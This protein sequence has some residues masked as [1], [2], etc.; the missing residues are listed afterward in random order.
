MTNL[1]KYFNF[2]CDKLLQLISKRQKP[3]NE[4]KVY[5]LK[6]DVSTLSEVSKCRG[7]KFEL[8]IKNG[9]NNL[10]DCENKSSDY[11]KDLL[12]NSQIGQ[13]FYQMKFDVPE[14]FYDDTG[15]K[16]IKFERFI[17]DI[18][19]VKE[20]DCKKKLMIYDAKSSKST[21]VSHQIFLNFLFHVWNLLTRLPLQ[22]FNI[23]FLL[24]KINKFFCEELPRIITTERPW[25][26]NSRCRTCD[27]VDK[28]KE[29]AE[30]DEI[31]IEDLTN[32]VKLNI[33]AKDSDKAKIKKIIRY[34]N[35]LESSPYLEAK[36]P[37]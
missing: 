3:S 29:D 32:Y 8:E 13:T 28:C 4:I 10:V 33:E 16:D 26:Y 23:D 18:I 30:G 20:V 6:T 34:D 14:N 27:F 17:P 7:I 24:P 19:E 31:D 12:K 35:K 11:N 2:D 5:E 22:T 25:H 9:L 36:K 37:K 15:I 21:R 1:S